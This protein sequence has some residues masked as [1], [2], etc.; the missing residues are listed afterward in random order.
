MAKTMAKE[1]KQKVATGVQDTR[2]IRDLLLH[3]RGDRPCQPRFAGRAGQ[4]RPDCSM[5]EFSTFS[6]RDPKREF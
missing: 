4:L 2:R 6:R 3:S 5:K 1:W